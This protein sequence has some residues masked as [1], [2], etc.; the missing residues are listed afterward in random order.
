M[1]GSPTPE[2]DAYLTAT[3]LTKHLGTP[4]YP[5]FRH[6]IFRRHSDI[7]INIARHYLRLSVQQ[8]YIQANRA[9]LE[10]DK[11]LVIN[12]LNLSWSN[13]K[14]KRFAH[15][16]AEPC[17]RFTLSAGNQDDALEKALKLSADY[18]LPTLDCYDSDAALARL[19]DENWWLRQL[20]RLQSKTNVNTER[21]IGMVQK[22]LGGYSGPVTHRYRQYQKARSQALLEST[23]VCNPEGVQVSLAEI[24]EHSIANPAVRRAELMVRI[25]GY[26]EVAQVYGDVG[27][28]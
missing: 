5:K 21:H 25:R 13:H 22:G 18:H 6:S 26:E 24:A 11:R 12:D 1:E 16:K 10:L 3:R 28:F 17:Q 23:M 14:L 15:S 7:S 19:L 27:E 2:S 20:R 4:D 9:L 8:D